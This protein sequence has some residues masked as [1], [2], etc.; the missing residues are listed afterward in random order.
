M[1]GSILCTTAVV[2][3]S[4]KNS[5]ERCL[6]SDPMLEIGQNIYNIFLLKKWHMRSR[7]E[8]GK[9]SGMVV[10]NAKRCKYGR[11]IYTPQAKASI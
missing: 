11:K 9:A 2:F 5:K 1:Q 4:G 7:L 3:L 8:S 10:I 6:P